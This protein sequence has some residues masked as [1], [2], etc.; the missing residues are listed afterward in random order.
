MTLACG[1]RRKRVSHMNTYMPR[2][3][4]KY[5]SIQCQINSLEKNQKLN[6]A[7]Q[8]SRVVQPKQL[9]IRSGLLFP[10]ELLEEGGVTGSFV[11]SGGVGIGEYIC[12]AFAAMCVA[13]VVGM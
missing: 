11:G 13:S 10:E 4:S 1:A 8:E 5:K 9:L 2:R 12:H 7:Q 6:N 3:R